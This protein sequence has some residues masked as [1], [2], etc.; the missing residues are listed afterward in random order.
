MLYD[1]TKAIPTA[2]CNCLKQIR[3][4]KSKV[5]YTLLS[6][7][8]WDQLNPFFPSLWDEKLRELWICSLSLRKQTAASRRNVSPKSS[9]GI[10]ECLSIMHQR[11]PQEKSP[12]DL[13]W[14]SCRQINHCLEESG[15]VLCSV[16][17]N[18]SY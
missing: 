10:F 4:N 12:S 17:F 18:L 1:C 3:G 11:G 5:N 7:L 13:R 16:Q 2:S 14:I 8:W 15:V 9:M 6:S